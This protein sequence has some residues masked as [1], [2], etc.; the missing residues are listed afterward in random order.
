MR[1]AQK[2]SNC[3]TKKERINFWTRGKIALRRKA[4]T[5][6]KPAGGGFK[7]DQA[8]AFR[9]TSAWREVWSCPQRSRAVENRSSENTNG[10]DLRRS[11]RCLF[12]RNGTPGFGW[13]TGGKN[14]V[15]VAGRPLWRFPFQRFSSLKMRVVLQRG[16]RLVFIKITERGIQ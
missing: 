16:C 12:D 13:D 2:K 11:R 8:F 9:V 4:A 14:T 15:I 1:E 6:A 3:A 7:K 5:K 10:E